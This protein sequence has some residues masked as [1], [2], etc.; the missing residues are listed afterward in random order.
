MVDSTAQL[1]SRSLAAVSSVFSRDREPC[2]IC[3]GFRV[4]PFSRHEVEL[5]HLR[6]R[7]HTCAIILTALNLLAQNMGWKVPTNDKRAST[8]ISRETNGALLL[9][10]VQTQYEPPVI[11]A[12]IFT[13]PYVEYEMGIR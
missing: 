3:L 7:C 12:R 4:G 13:D 5:R 11:G 2:P 9:D 10:A 1:I 8:S 6:R